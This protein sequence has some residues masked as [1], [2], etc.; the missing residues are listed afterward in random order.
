MEQISIRFYCAQRDC[1]QTMPKKNMDDPSK[2]RDQDYMT[3]YECNGSLLV[4][5]NDAETLQYHIVNSHNP[6]ET[7]TYQ[8]HPNRQNTRMV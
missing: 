7:E 4:T 5:I 1:M 8:Y 3:R 6:S 2:Q